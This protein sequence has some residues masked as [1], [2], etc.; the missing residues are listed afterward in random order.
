MEKIR[1]GADEVEA[2]EIVGSVA[3]KRPILVDDIVST[4]GTIAAA[5]R[6]ALARGRRPARWS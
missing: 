4:G 1:R 2:L 3:G 5:L 6:A